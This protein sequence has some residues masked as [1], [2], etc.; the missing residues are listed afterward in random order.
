MSVRRTLFAAAVAA[1]FSVP[2]L[3]QS[4]GFVLFGDPDPQAASLPAEQKFVAPITS[5]Y[6]H[7]NSFTGTDVRA[8]FLYHSF[9]DDIALDGGHANVYALQVRVALTNNLQLVA[10]KDGYTDLESGLL[11]DDGWNDVAAGLK[12]S[13]LQDYDRQLFAAVGV[14]YEFPFGDHDVLHNDDE[15]RVWASIDKGIDNKLHVGAVVNLFIADDEESTDPG[16][17]GNAHLRLSWHLHADYYLCDWFS[18]VIEVNGYH[19]LDEGLEVLPFTG[20]DVTNL[21]GDSEDV[22]T[23]GFGGEFRP[24][25]GKLNLG[26]RPAID[27]PITDNE[28][29]YGWRFTFSV[30]YEF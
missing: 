11:K 21:G 27:L 23:V 24:M 3:G 8:L 22:I 5:P 6:Y 13:F 18:P 14:G 1:I 28:D 7:E 19:T 15:W 30:I 25:P 9:P 16:D 12:W 29:L 20:A 2:A 10:Y 26:L 4:Q 17:F